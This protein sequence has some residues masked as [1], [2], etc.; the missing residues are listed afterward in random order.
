MC[1]EAEANHKKSSQETN[2]FEMAKKVTAKA[3]NPRT[4]PFSH[5]GLK[6]TEVPSLLS[7]P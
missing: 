2:A 1:P 3:Q 4:F 6:F 7:V 5:E